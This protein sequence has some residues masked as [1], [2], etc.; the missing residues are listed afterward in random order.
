MELKYLVIFICRAY[1]L[2]EGLK[3]EKGIENESKR[4]KQSELG[5]KEGESS[6][7]KIEMTS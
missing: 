7:N 5:E 1:R 2:N 4:N 6:M 3:R